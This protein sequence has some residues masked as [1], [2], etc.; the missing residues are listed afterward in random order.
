MS[1][2]SPIPYYRLSGGGND[3]LALVEPTEAPTP[4]TLRDWCRRGVSAGADGVL[5]LYREAEGARMVHFNADGSRSRFC[6]NGSRCAAW[7]AFFLEW[8][9]DSL[10]LHTDLGLCRCQLLGPDR[11]TIELPIEVSN[12]RAVTLETPAGTVSGFHLRVGTPHL[13]LPTHRSLGDVPLLEQ[14]PG[15]RHHPDLGPQGANVHWVRFLDANRGEI[16]SYERGVEAETLACGSGVVAMVAVGISRG[17]LTLPATILTAGGFELEVGGTVLRREL[18]TP[19]VSGDA[20]IVARGELLA[21]ASELPEPAMW[22][23]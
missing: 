22:A 21:G 10:E 15:L 12:P 8:R 13:V 5:L 7:L 11:V 14:G 17:E 20:R 9:T 23:L 2:P 19:H 4:Q 18:T 16:R 3:F 1:P 6:L